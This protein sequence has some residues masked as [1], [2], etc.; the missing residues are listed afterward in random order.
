MEHLSL[1]MLHGGGLEGSS[2]TV[3]PGRYAKKV[4]GY[5]HLSPWGPLS[6]RGA[7]IPG[8]SIDE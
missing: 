7:R 3:D 8:T 4:S 2:F 6:V 5:G 1:Q